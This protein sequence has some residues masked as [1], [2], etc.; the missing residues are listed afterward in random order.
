MSCTVYHIAIDY[1]PKICKLP[2]QKKNIMLK[3]LYTAALAI[4]IIGLASC[5]GN[6]DKTYIDKTIV[7]EGSENTTNAQATEVVPSENPANAIVPNT[8]VPGT[9]TLIP[10]VTTQQ[11]NF[12]PQ[13]VGQQPNI[14]TTTQ[15]P[16]QATAAGMNPAHGAPGHRCDIAV[17]APLNSKPAANNAAQPNVVT[18][19]QPANNFT[20]TEQPAQKTAPGMNPA[21]G[22]PGHRCD[23]SVGAPLDSKPSTPA[24]KDDKAITAIPPL[25]TPVKPDSSK[26]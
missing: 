23:I 13:T 24:A 9:S 19:Q 20:V 11:V 16:L 5:A 12:N 3:K 10:G 14:V 17:G 26:N 1:R 18:T 15:Q 22:E 8:G 7:P 6:N 4:G 21:H 25:L 2:N